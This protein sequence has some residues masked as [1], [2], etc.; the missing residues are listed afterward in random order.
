[1][2]AGARQIRV[3]LLSEISRCAASW[4]RDEAR[5]CEQ[6]YA[7]AKEKKGREAESANDRERPEA[8]RMLNTR[9]GAEAEVRILPGR[10]IRS[11]NPEREDGGG[12]QPLL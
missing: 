3:K 11:E 12:L 2:D 1:M 10:R 5:Q 7:A 9:C 6:V 8:L 4:L